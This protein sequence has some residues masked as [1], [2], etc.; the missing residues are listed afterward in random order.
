MSHKDIN[1]VY[2]YNH[3]FARYRFRY[4]ITIL[5]I[6]YRLVFYLKLSSTLYVCPYLTG[7][8]TLC[9]RYEPK[10]LMLYICLWRWYINITITILDIIHRL[11]FYLKYNVSE[12]EFCL[13]LEVV[14]TVVRTQLGAIDEASPCHRTGSKTSGQRQNPVSKTS[15]FK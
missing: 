2:S 8:N 6:I 3:L 12:T 11:V 15:Y 13:R 4:T 10:R 7:N 14:R 5:D 1:T 9:L